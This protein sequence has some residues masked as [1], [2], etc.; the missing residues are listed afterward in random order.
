MGWHRLGSIG[1]ENRVRVLLLN[2]AGK[3]RRK[4]TVQIATPIETP[5]RED[6]SDDGGATTDTL[7][8]C[9]DMMSLVPRS[10]IGLRGVHARGR[11][12]R[13]CPPCKCGKAE[14]VA[15]LGMSHRLVSSALP[16]SREDV[17]IISIAS[18]SAPF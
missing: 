11:R 2:F 16:P 4:P 14:C 7:K 5:R 6:N 10:H 18:S 12:A 3:P 8:A 9:Y 15:K 1:A 13:H 17:V